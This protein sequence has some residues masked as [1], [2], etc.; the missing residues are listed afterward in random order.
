MRPT[1]NPKSKLSSD[2]RDMIP[3]RQYTVSGIP[4][5][6]WK[7]ASTSAGLVRSTL[8]VMAFEPD[9][10]FGSTMSTRISRT[11]GVSGSVWRA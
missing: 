10:A 11:S 3:C 4:Y 7:S 1:F 8:I 6:V 5:S 9:G 2:P